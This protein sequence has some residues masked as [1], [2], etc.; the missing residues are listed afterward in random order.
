MAGILG[1]T[2][3]AKTGDAALDAVQASRDRGAPHD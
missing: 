3:F 1:A 2:D